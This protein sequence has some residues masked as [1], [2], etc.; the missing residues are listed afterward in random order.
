MLVVEQCEIAGQRPVSTQ[1]PKS[2]D[3]QG[4]TARL[5]ARIDQ[6]SSRQ[7]LAI[8]NPYRELDWKLPIR[9]TNR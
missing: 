1:R 2:A 9:G 6:G 5:S 8:S 3:A 4:R 7:I